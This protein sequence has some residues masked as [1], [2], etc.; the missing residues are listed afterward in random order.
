MKWP[1]KFPSTIFVVET[2]SIFCPRASCS[3]T[4]CYFPIFLSKVLLF[5]AF[6]F[7][8][9]YHDALTFFPAL[10]LGLFVMHLKHRLL[11]LPQ[12][13]NSVTLICCPIFN[14]RHGLMD[15]HHY[16]H[17]HHLVVGT[18]KSLRRYHQETTYVVVSYCRCFFYCSVQ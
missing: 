6:L 7:L 10:L 14:F 11:P 8:F 12:L 2:A 9:N 5:V 16:Q 13:Y 17:K 3:V 18:T 1:A 15:C 4:L